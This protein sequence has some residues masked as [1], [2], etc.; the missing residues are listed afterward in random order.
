MQVQSDIKGFG[1]VQVAAS[2]TR[3]EST[4]GDLL[5][6]LGTIITLGANGTLEHPKQMKQG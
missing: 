3:A 6:K 5:R 2:L 1:P 4:Q